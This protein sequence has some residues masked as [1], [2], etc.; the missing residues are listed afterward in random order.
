[1]SN[2]LNRSVEFSIYV[3]V[4]LLPLFF[5]P[6]SYEALEYN[7]QYLLFFLVSIGFLAW[8][9]KMIFVDRELKFKK[10]LLDIPIF[11]FLFVSILSAIFS[12]D[13]FS[14]LFGTYGRFSD[15]L[16][17]ILSLGILYFLI[18]NNVTQVSKLIKT[19]L[20]SVLF[21]V[22]FSYFSIFGIWE[23]LNTVFGEFLPQIILQKIFNPVSGSME[24]YTPRKRNIS[25]RSQYAGCRYDCA[26]GGRSLAC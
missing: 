14:S 2:F 24:G 16:I 7:K 25:W 18:T 9:A 26:F 22:L 12:V 13:R 8:I 3:L 19:L 23:K 10:T 11:T 15:G 1:M 20:L 5:L 6:F 4:F 21:V 17:G